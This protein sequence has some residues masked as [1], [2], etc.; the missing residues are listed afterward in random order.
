MSGNR[1]SARLKGRSRPLGEDKQSLNRPIEAMADK[2]HPQHR[3]RGG[4]RIRH[5]RDRSTDR[6]EIVSLGIAGMTLRLTGIGRRGRDQR[7]Q[8]TLSALTVGRVKVTKGQAEIDDQR[9]QRQP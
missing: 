7:Y 6:T 3:W 5:C 2:F 4:K 8:A 1:W 9:E